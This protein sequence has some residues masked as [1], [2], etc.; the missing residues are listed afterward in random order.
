MKDSV[1]TIIK[2]DWLQ[3]THVINEAAFATATN[4]PKF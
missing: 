2:H 4:A 1:A 3:L